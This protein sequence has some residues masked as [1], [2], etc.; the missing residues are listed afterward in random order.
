MDGED[1]DRD[2]GIHHGA[3]IL[4]TIAI[5]LD[6]MVQ[7]KLIDNRAVA[8]RT[9]D[10]VAFFNELPGVEKTKQDLIDGFKALIPNNHFGIAKLGS[11]TKK[12]TRKVKKHARR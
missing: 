9:G 1:F 5:Y 7:G 11:P 2:T 3:F 6:A 8:G 4:S 10:L 12:T